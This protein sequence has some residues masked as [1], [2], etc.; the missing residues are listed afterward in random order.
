LARFD[1]EADVLR[2]DL[3]GLIKKLMDNGLLKVSDA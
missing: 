1:V 2:R 3:F